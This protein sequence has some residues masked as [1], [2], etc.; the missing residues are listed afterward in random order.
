MNDVAMMGMA[1]LKSCRLIGP[2]VRFLIPC[3][4]IISIVKKFAK[5]HKNPVLTIAYSVISGKQE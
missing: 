4:Q 3:I 1:R 2:Y 5:I